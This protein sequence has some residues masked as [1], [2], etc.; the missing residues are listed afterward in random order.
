[1]CVS[2]CVRACVFVYVCVFGSVC[3]SVSQ[4]RALVCEQSPD[5]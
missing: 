4:L 2:V 5:L 1:V 3:I